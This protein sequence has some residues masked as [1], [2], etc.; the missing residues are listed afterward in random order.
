MKVLQLIALL[1]GHLAVIV[2]VNITSNSAVFSQSSVNVTTDS[3][4]GQAQSTTISLDRAD[5]RQP[6]ILR[7]QGFANNS[8]V[9]MARVAV[10]INGKLIKTIAN[11]SLELNLAPMITVGRYEVEISG[12]SS[13]SDGTISVKFT[14]KNTNVTQ[15]VSGYGTIKQILF[16]N[17]Q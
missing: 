8:P 9:K 16:I 13:R 3:D 14:G 2:A 17:I 1:L 4:N 11:N 12:T 5:L 7:V 6:H 15:Q 10:R